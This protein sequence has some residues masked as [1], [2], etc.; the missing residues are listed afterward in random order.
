MYVLLGYSLNVMYVL[1]GYS[2]DVMYVLLAMV[3]QHHVSFS[4]P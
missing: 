1:L 4:Y 2:L 3:T